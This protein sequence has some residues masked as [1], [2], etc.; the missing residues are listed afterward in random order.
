MIYFYLALL[1]WIV[2]WGINVWIS[3]QKS[4]KILNIIPPILF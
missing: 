4:L 1:F 3:R 2:A